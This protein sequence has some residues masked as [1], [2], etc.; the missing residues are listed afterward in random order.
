MNPPTATITDEDPF[1]KTQ[2]LPADLTGLGAALPTD[3]PARE[4]TR[5]QCAAYFT[6]WAR[7]IDAADEAVAAQ[8]REY[9]LCWRE[10]KAWEHLYPSAITPAAQVQR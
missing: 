1:E 3:P 5:E 9:N 7:A 2:P 10:F 6:E 8:R 4:R